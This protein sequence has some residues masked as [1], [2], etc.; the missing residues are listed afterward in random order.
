MVDRFGL[1]N[2][3]QKCRVQ[4]G[5]TNDAWWYENQRNIEVHVEINGSHAVLTISRQK[6]KSWLDRT[7][8]K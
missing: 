4:D 8:P 5:E 6:L 2:N 3:P 1:S 7:E